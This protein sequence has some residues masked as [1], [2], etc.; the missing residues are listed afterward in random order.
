[1]ADMDK[2][3]QNLILRSDQM[4][5]LMRDMRSSVVK[6]NEKFMVEL[7]DITSSFKETLRNT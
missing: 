3:S 1:M 2:V 5:T 6:L 4:D 7:E